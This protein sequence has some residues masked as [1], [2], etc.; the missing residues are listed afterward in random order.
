M[1]AQEDGRDLLLILVDNGPNNVSAVMAG[2]AEGGMAEFEP[3]VL[4]V[5]ATMAYSG[6]A[7]SK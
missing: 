3:T 1:M 4:E 5:V 6:T 7:G 2:A